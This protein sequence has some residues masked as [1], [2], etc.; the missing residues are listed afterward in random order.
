MERLTQKSTWTGL[1]LAA[2]SI[3][4]WTSS[5]VDMYVALIVAVAGVV[6]MVW[7]PKKK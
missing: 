1:A 3:F 6:L 2:G 7:N 4:G 5:E